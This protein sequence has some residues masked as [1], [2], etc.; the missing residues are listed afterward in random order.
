M[1]GLLEAVDRL[2]DRV[3]DEG[4]QALVNQCDVEWG[5]TVQAQHQVSAGAVPVVSD[6]VRPTGR[7]SNAC[8][9]AMGTYGSECCGCCRE[10]GNLAA[11]ALVREHARGIRL[12]AE[13]ARRAAELAAL[14]KVHN[15]FG[16]VAAAVLAS[17]RGCPT[18]GAR[19]RYLCAP[20]TAARSS[21]GGAS[22]TRRCMS[23]GAGRGLGALMASPARPCSAPDA[24]CN[25]PGARLSAC[26]RWRGVA[27]EWPS[28]RVGTSG[29]ARGVPP[30]WLPG[31]R[32]GKGARSRWCGQRAGA[33][34]PRRRLSAGS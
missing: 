18:H 5:Q 28:T 8:G 1:R 20:R 31:G 29:S 19:R 26:C 2:E 16:A 25:A 10:R 3:A 32:A 22:R 34:A 12:D 24:A 14:W 30:R 9:V 7:P 11:D 15:V 33:T 21:L 17:A 6:C 23:S 4:L 27:P 13:R